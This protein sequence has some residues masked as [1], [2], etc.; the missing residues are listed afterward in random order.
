M[1]MY[2]DDLPTEYHAYR[3]LVICSNTLEGGGIPIAYEGQ[4]VFLVGR[5]LVAQETPTVWL[6][7]ITQGS[8]QRSP[9][10]KA[11]TS[12][13]PNISVR[14]GL[15]RG[16]VAIFAHRT[17]V[18]EARN[19]GLDRCVI[20]TLDLRPIGLNIVGDPTKLLIGTNTF[21]GNHFKGAGTMIALGAPE[22]P[23]GLRK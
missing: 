9:V 3:T 16:Y 11:N 7:A 23:M 4:Y 19:E 6:S 15:R 8:P 22:E 2:F 18:L 14:R 5:P 20:D 10:V 1:T 12:L 17:K 21:A 13:H